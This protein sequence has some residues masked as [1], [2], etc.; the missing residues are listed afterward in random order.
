MK[1]LFLIA[2]DSPAKR[3]LLSRIVRKNLDVEILTTEST[4]QA[5]EMINEHVEFAAAFVDYEIPSENGP[6][7]IAHLKKHNPGCLVAL[8]T[9]ADSRACEAE[10]R[11]AGA[12]AFV[13]TSWPLDR[14]ESSFN[15]LL[16]EWAAVME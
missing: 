3:E 16:A 14:V 6:A 9:S 7:V 15:Q 4:E 1:P 12:T 13:C 8:V 5:H 10:A 11:K 2:D